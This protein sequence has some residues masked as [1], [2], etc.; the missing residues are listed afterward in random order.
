MRIC[1]LVII[2]III[3]LQIDKVNSQNL[4]INVV[5][6]NAGVVKKGELI[7]FEIVINNTSPIKVVPGF[8]VR[9]QI[10]FPNTLVDV[11]NKGHVLP[12]GWQII[13]N[14]K[15]VVVLTNGTDVIGQNEKRSI[16]ISIKGIGLGGPSTIMGNM[17]FSN[18]I[19]PGNVPGIALNGDLL[20]DNI[21]TSTVKVVK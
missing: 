19:T 9:P 6:Q 15:G 8:K 7:F 18:G 3:F 10:T 1:R 12:E 13:S 16:L 2:S 17:L 11:Q 4:S 14:T 21:S 20:A 5:T